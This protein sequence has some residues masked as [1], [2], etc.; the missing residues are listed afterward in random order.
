MSKIYQRD[1]HNFFDSLTAFFVSQASYPIAFRAQINGSTNGY[2]SKDRIGFSGFPNVTNIAISLKP[3]KLMELIAKDGWPTT[4]ELE[5]HD[6]D[7]NQSPRNFPEMP[8][9][10]L[11]G[12]K[13]LLNSTAIPMY[14]E[15]F[16]SNIDEVR[17][18]FGN[19]S[20]KWPNVWNFGRVIRNAFSHGGGIFISNPK[21][22]PVSWKGLTYSPKDNCKQVLFN[23][24][25]IADVIILL[26][27]LDQEISFT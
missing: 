16:E 3:K 21:S 20:S 8:N 26:E 14:V 17:N 6:L 9:T 24:M 4:L 25:G 5:V 10:Q 2:T 27:D 12:L 15:Y 18:K 22:S 7:S 1:K 23:D 13:G 19:D 11:T